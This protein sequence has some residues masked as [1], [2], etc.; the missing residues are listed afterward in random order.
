M[1]PIT[2]DTSRRIICSGVAV[3]F[4][5]PICRARSASTIVKFVL[6]GDELLTETVT[7][8]DCVVRAELS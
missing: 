6:I 2:G 7:A 3:I 1:P 4:P 5:E 8:E